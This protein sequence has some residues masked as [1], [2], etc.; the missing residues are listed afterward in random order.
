MKTAEKQVL[1][2]VTRVMSLAEV[3]LGSFRSS[4]MELFLPKCFEK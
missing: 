3:Y 4:N 1:A 2:S